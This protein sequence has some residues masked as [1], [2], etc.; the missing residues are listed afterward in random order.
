MGRLR[1]VVAGIGWPDQGRRLA[2]WLNPVVA[3]SA[4]SSG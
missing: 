4:P 3:S 2:R 1:R